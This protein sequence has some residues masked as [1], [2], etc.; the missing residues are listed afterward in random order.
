MRDQNVFK[1]T[2]NALAFKG[3]QN[4]DNII[5]KTVENLKFLQNH[6]KETKV[7]FFL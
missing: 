4:L 2:E 6:L 1:F 7:F 3:V 5:E